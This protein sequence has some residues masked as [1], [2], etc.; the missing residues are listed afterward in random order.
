MAF[1]TEWPPW[2]KHEIVSNLADAFEQEYWQ[3][4]NRTTHVNIRDFIERGLAE[5]KSIATMASE[6]VADGLDE[7]Y[8]GRAKNI[9]RTESGNALNGARKVA[10]NR[11]TE[12]VPQLKDMLKQSWLSVL[13]TTTRAAHAHLDGVPADG[14]GLWNLGGVRVPWPG[15]YSLPPENR[16][17]CQCTLQHEFGME[18]QEA[19]GLINDYN[20]R[21]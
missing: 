1:M 3:E 2:M 21:I 18:E 10:M 20:Q 13:G 15:H 12:E 14:D 19:Q 16:C 7:F 5:G 9:A 17:N 8:H 4:I 11:L 6:L